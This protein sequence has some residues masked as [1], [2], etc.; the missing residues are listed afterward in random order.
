MVLQLT[1]FWYSGAV[2]GHLYL[3]LGVLA[4]GPCC[5]RASSEN[6]T[7]LLLGGAVFFFVFFIHMHSKEPTHGLRNTHPQPTGQC[8]VSACL[9][10]P[11][12]LMAL[13]VCW[14]MT[15]LRLRCPTTC[16][17]CPR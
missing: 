15:R 13:L 16:Q 5:S 12:R 17:Q 10:G 9:P 11:L 4:W 3:G 7:T 2:L 1:V 14:K 8:L 6:L